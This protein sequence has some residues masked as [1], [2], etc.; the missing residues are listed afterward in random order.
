MLKVMIMLH[1]VHNAVRLGLEV[2]QQWQ[3]VKRV[4][5]GRQDDR[6]DKIQALLGVPTISHTPLRW[7]ALWARV[8]HRLHDRGIV[9]LQVGV[10]ANQKL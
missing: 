2:S 10:P 9:R 8:L 7:T 3:D 1:F 6:R 4:H 5:L